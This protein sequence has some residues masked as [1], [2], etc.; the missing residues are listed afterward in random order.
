MKKSLIALAALAAT[1][2]VSA[3]SSV[4]MFGVLDMGYNIK[5]WKNGG[6]T[7]SK[8]AGVQDGAVAGS[9]F[10]FRGTEDL[11]GGMRAEFMIE[12]GLS[13]TSQQLTNARTSNSGHQVDGI[14]GSGRSLTSL[15]RQTYIGLNGGFG[16]VRIGYQYTNLYELATLAGYTMTSEGLHG[17]D[18]A[19][20]AQTSGGTRANGLTYVTPAM[21]GVTARIQYGA[22]ADLN[23]YESKVAGLSNGLKQERTSLMA[24]YDGG[25]LSAALAFTQYK[26][27]TGAPGVAITTTT[28][29][30]TQIGASYNLGPAIIG[31]TF[32]DG[33][34]GAVSATKTKA[35]QIGVRVPMGATTLVGGMGSS[36]GKQAGTKNVDVKTWQVGALYDLS[37]RTQVYAY[38]GNTK[39]DG[40]A[41]TAID[42]KTNTIVGVRHSF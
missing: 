12:Q 36:V 35:Q 33:T 20:L 39:D 40:L 25:P 21:S 29:K 16:T 30:V 9:R 23:S 19:H 31:G 24:K 26:S 8:S 22:G 41:A 42:K 27:G 28:A 1:G 7:H 11:G 14:T 18:V 3:Q 6:T 32:L 13:G 38:T 34:D 2:L 5:E 4:T 10:G 37:K 17:G 15:N